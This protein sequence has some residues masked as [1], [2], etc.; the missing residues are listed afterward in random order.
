M[1]TKMTVTCWKYVVG[2]NTQLKLMFGMF[3]LHIQRTKSDAKR[4]I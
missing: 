3:L 4:H 2:S 1:E